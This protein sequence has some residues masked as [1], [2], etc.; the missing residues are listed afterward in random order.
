MEAL[1]DKLEAIFK[2][3]VKPNSYLKIMLGLFAEKVHVSL[4]FGDR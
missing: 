3:N 1:S 4:H 2:A